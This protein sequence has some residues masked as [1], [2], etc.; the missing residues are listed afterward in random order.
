MKFLGL[1]ASMEGYRHRP[2]DN[3]KIILREIESG[4]NFIHLTQ[5]R[6]RW[7]YL[8]N[9]KVNLRVSQKFEKLLSSSAIGGFSWKYSVS[10]V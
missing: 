5:D 2:E 9:T 6:D 1:V 8:V 3:I 10:T 4:G 7:H